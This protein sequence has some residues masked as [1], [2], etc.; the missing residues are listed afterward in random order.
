VTFNPTNQEPT[1][2]H[3]AIHTTAATQRPIYTGTGRRTRCIALLASVVFST[4]LLGSV[5][6]GMTAPANVA[7][8]SA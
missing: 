5:V 3:A 2:T 8:A 1:M 4:A 7:T 6:I